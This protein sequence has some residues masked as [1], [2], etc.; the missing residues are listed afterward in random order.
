M[1]DQH[2][3]RRPDVRW[4]RTAAL[5]FNSPIAAK[6]AITI[7]ANAM[8]G[9]SSI[10]KGEGLSVLRLAPGA[11]ELLHPLLDLSPDRAGIGGLDAQDHGECVIPV[12]Q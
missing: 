8:P 4:S 12:A 11:R 9:R 7:V 1:K 3:E 10:I 5:A 6:P 2:Q